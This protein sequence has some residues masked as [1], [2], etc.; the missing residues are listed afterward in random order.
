MN[1]AT[2]LADVILANSI[3]N[4]EKI[5]DEEKEKLRISILN[6]IDEKISAQALK[7]TMMSITRKSHSADMLESVLIVNEISDSNPNKV[8]KHKF[9][10][11]SPFEDYRLLHAIHKFGLLNWDKV[12]TFVGNGRT[13]AQC[14]QRW[15]RCMNPTL[16]KE[17]WTQEEEEKLLSLIDS[18]GVRGWTQI[19]RMMGNR[20][21]V[22]CRYRYNQILKE[23]RYKKIEIKPQTETKTQIPE[24]F[25]KSLLKLQIFE[26][27]K[28]FDLQSEGSFIINKQSGSNKKV[29]ND[30]NIMKIFS[31]LFSF[32]ELLI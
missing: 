19:A 25:E 29:E 7:D 13:R 6:R 28:L 30:H 16:S 17:V 24:N 18:E 2:P 20:S 11:W 8:I 21:D 14:S 5:S 15:N 32:G 10:L 27:A 23:N 26:A 9:N 31:P 1:S 4:R 22:Q 12:A 3:K